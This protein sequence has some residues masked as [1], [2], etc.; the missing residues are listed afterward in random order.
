VAGACSVID[1]VALLEAVRHAVAAERATGAI[2]PTGARASGIVG[3]IAL[4]GAVREAVAAERAAA[5]VGQAG[6]RTGPIV[7]PVAL[8][9]SVGHSVSAG[10]A[11]GAVGLAGT[12]TDCIVAPVALLGVVRDSVSAEGSNAAR[13]R[14]VIRADVPGGLSQLSIDV[15]RK[16]RRQIQRSTVRVVPPRLEV[17]VFGAGHD[18]DKEVVGVRRWRLVVALVTRRIE[19]LGRPVHVVAEVRDPPLEIEILAPTPERDR[20][21]NHDAGVVINHSNAVSEDSVDR[22]ILDCGASGAN[23]NSILRSVGNDRISDGNV[24][25]TSVYRRLRVSDVEVMD[26]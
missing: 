22:T 14:G 7:G 4:L 8:L 19:V 9:G 17:Q 21:P 11:A 23:T 5:A 25:T 20:V 2:G 13:A 1:S 12:R 10:L 3:P 24:V 6:A 26:E 15:I 18:R 16:E